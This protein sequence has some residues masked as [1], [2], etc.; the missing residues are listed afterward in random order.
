M[1][2]DRKTH[3]SEGTCEKCGGPC[4]RKYTRDADGNLVD[5]WYWSLMEETFQDAVEISRGA[6][7]AGAT[8]IAQRLVATT[9][10]VPAELVQR[11]KIF[12]TREPNSTMST[13][14]PMPCAGSLRTSPT[15]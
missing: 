2:F 14:S 1:N 4:Q 3:N 8:A 12:G 13:M 6:G 11:R 7:N 5:G 10:D 15:R 9:D